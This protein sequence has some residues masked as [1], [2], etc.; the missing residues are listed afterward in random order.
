MLMITVTEHDSNDS[1]TY[2]SEML[3]AC[4]NMIMVV[5]TLTLTFELCYLL[6][7]VGEQVNC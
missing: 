4:L 6:C 5:K 3:T 7:I 1:Q 2:I